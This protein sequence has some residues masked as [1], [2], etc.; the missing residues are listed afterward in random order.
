MMVRYGLELG[1][2]DLRYR[3]PPFSIYALARTAAGHTHNTNLR[4]L[5]NPQP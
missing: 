4:K 2:E 5:R 3:N 1:L